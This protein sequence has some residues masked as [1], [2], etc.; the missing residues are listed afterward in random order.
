[1]KTNMN[2]GRIVGVLFLALMIVYTIG[3]TLI[4]PILNSPNYLVEASENKAQL[5]IGVLF[6]LMNGVAYLGI[7]ALLYPI[8]KKFSEH[9][10]L[11]YLGLRILEFAMQMISDISPLLL[12][13][14][15]QDFVA[16]DTQDTSSFQALGSILLGLRFWANQMVFI[17]YALGAFVFYYA[18]YHLKLIPRFLSVWGLIGAPL[19]LVNVLLDSFDLGLGGPIGLGMV[20]GLNEIVLGIWLILKGFNHKLKLS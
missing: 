9:L 7:A 8:L 10:A 6:E 5:I 1:M 19:V 12:I 16:M 14:A 15:S 2:P 4:D 13:T 17:A 3:A 18:T 11:L 20:M